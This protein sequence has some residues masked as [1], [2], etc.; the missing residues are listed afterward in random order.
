[1]SR[2]AESHRIESHRIELPVI[3]GVDSI[4]GFNTGPEIISPSPA[5]PQSTSS[6]F[7]MDQNTKDE[8]CGCS[9][10]WLIIGIILVCIIVPLSFHYVRYDQYAF[11]RNIYGSTDTTHLITQG[12]YF[13]PITHDLVTFPSTY[14]MVSF[15]NSQ[16]T[17]LSVF[18]N[19][20]L[21]FNIDVI[22]FYRLP[23]D[24]LGQIYNT[25]STA[26]DS[27]VS[28]IAKAVL[29]NQAVSFT[30]DDYAN[31]HQYIQSQ[32]ASSLSQT[33]TTQLKVYTPIYNVLLL[34]IYYPGSV[35]NQN[36]QSAIEFQNNQ[37]QQ[38]QQA[39]DLIDIET[40]RLLSLIWANS[41]I[42]INFANT[43]ANAIVSNAVSVSS[44]IV[45]SAR[46][47]GIQ[48]TL[49]ALNITDPSLRDQFFQIT[50]ILDNANSPKVLFN[51]NTNPLL[52]LGN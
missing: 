14:Q 36:L 37:V 13:Y 39:V 19:E 23:S 46:A 21:Q 27:Q 42:T 5:P 18:S 43:S 8:I 3:A 7:T 20:G 41:N 15:L 4:R 24:T 44:A 29:K 30:L 48:N 40:S 11:N 51:I 16:G 31:N 2:R 45:T 26:Y 9:I 35:I 38:F 28:N 34:N 12:R 1:M 49:N 33:L 50:S 25:Y 17:S 22:F 52:T 32:F 6:S 47:L 10:F